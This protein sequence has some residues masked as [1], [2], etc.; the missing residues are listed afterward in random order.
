MRTQTEATGHLRYCLFPTA[1]GDCGIAWSERGV[2]RLQLPESDRAATER[3]LKS[4]AVGAK[5]GDPPAPI[6][7]VIEEIQR[8]ARGERVDFSTIAVDLPGIEPLSRDVYAA[9]RA[10]GWGETASYG[11][12]ARRIGAPDAREVGQA[13]SRNPVPLIVPCHRVLASDGKLHGFSAYGGTLT[14]ERLL[15]LE[16]FGADAPR[17]PGL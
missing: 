9:A 4:R 12:I 2:T 3:R 15:S 8:Y 14:K 6:C 17:L 13:L 1:I 5:A 10:L 16:G 11:D 7:Q